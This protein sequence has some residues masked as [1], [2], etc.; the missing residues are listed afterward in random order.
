MSLLLKVWRSHREVS[1]NEGGTAMRKTRGTASISGAYIEFQVAVLKA[2]PR[3]ISPD[4][5]LA[6]TLNGELL[7]HVL[8]DALSPSGKLAS[9]SFSVPCEGAFPDGGA[10]AGGA[11]GGVRATQPR[12]D[13][14]G[15]A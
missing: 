15:S 14:G 6:W 1:R 8:K 11:D 3:D 5:A 2:L 4:V 12:S 7:A 10:G 9:N 13:F